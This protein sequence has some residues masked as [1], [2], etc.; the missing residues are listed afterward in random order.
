M[1]ETMIPGAAMEADNSTG[2]ATNSLYRLAMALPYA[3]FAGLVALLIYCHLR[4]EPVNVSD[5]DGLVEWATVV[6]FGLIAALSFTAAIVHRSRMSRAQVILIVLLG[7]VAL[8]AIGE[9][10]SWGQRWFGFEPPESM[11]S[12][13]GG[14]G[15]WA[16]TT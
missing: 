15:R 10:L 16:T 11:K 9:E 14:A 12:G 2:G 1:S 7:L 6:A 8:M 5:E 4:G 13:G 3:I